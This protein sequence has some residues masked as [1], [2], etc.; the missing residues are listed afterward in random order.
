MWYKSLCN[1]IY[2][3]LCDIHYNSRLHNMIQYI[4][5]QEN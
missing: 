4:I 3:T 2:K 1:I 5:S